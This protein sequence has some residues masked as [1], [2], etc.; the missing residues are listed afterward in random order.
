MSSER[1]S[2][3]IKLRT[4]ASRGSMR[5]TASGKQPHLDQPMSESREIS[6]RNSIKALLE[7]FTRTLVTVSDE[8]SVLFGVRIAKHCW[9]ISMIESCIVS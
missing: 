2:K 8:G 9:D 6:G 5:H 3:I 7:A 4:A 1:S